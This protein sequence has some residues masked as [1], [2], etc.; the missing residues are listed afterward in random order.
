MKKIVKI[1]TIAFIII[2]SANLFGGPGACMDCPKFACPEFV[3]DPD[4]DQPLNLQQRKCTCPHV[5]F[6][7]GDVTKYAPGEN[8]VSFTGN[9]NTNYTPVAKKEDE[10]YENPIL[11][12]VVIIGGIAYFCEK[13]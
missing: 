10:W 6:R 3:E 4:F 2:C 9:P 8:S 1:T 12:I 13:Y 7:H 5:Y 11:W